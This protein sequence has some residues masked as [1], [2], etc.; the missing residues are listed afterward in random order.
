MNV[1]RPL[2]VYLGFFSLVHFLGE[3]E[4]RLFDI[5]HTDVNRKR[6]NSD[7]WFVTSCVLCPRGRHQLERRGWGGGRGRGEW[8]YVTWQPSH[9]LEFL[10]YE[11]F[12]IFILSQNKQYHDY[13]FTIRAA[14]CTYWLRVSCPITFPT[15]ANVSSPGTS[16]CHMSLPW[17]WG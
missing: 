10:S 15:V 6:L 8:H 7:W 13:G 5:C 12:T 14:D 3:R 9:K 17:G 1:G 11:R 2:T 4:G 16:G